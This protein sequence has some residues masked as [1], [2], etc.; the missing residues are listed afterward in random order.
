VKARK[1]VRSMGNELTRNL[2]EREHAAVRKKGQ[3]KE[4][5][6]EGPKNEEGKEGVPGALSE[7]AKENELAKGGGKRE[8][9]HCPWAGMN[10]ARRKQG[11]VKPGA[12]VIG[13][14]ISWTDAACVGLR[15]KGRT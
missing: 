2:A 9:L 11:N 4:R 3:Q 8:E 14:K 10:G 13:K 1:K 6:K 15:R 5:K 7:P 12:V